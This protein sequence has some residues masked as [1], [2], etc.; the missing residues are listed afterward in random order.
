[1]VASASLHNEDEI[2]NLDIRNGD[3]VIIRRAGD[4]IP[5]VVEVL[6][7]RRKAGVSEVHFP[8]TCPSCG[9]KIVR[10]EGEAAYRCLSPTC[11]AQLKGRLFHFAS[12]GG[13]DIIGLGGKL[14]V[15]LIAKELVG[16]A[17]DLFFLTKEH[18]LQLDLMADKRVQNLLNSIEHA[19]STDLPR[20]IY[21]LGIIGVGETA[22]RLLAV[23]F[24]SFKKLEHSTIEQLE[25]IDGI[26]PIIARNIGDFFGNA[27][28]KKMIKK[29]RKGG[30][31]FPDYARREGADDLAGKSFVITGTLSQPRSYFKNAIEGHGGSVSGS[32]SGR[33]DYLLCGAEPGSKLP[34]AKKLGITVISETEFAE[35]LKSS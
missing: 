19:R 12:R 7:E 1:M 18:L 29:L 31:E 21:A 30:V 8:A 10:P 9:K 32:V 14:A 20:I 26:G 3:R 16:D 23:E 24:G 34:K 17:A 27:E 25:Q 35:M 28:T 15:Q 11:P 2:R 6:D 5:E 13:F 4:V 22:A 33:I